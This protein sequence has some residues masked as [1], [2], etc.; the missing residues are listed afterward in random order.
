MSTDN[1]NLADWTDSD[2]L[3][4][5]QAKARIRNLL[6]GRPYED[7]VSAR[8]LA[9]QCPGVSTSTVR[10]LVAEVRDEYNI[11]VY[12]RGSGYWELQDGEE[13]D[14]AIER[15]R[16][17]IRTKEETMSELAAAFNAGRF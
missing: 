6:K 14:D 17:Q 15:I 16:E 11:P 4:H 13:L 5:E 1:R 2:E 7:R 8:E 10:D 3:T 9:E 12:S